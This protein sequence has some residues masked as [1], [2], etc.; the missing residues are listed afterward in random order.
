VIAAALLAHAGY[1]VG[2]ETVTVY[3]RTHEWIGLEEIV[4][5]TAIMYHHRYQ[6]DMYS[7]PSRTASTW[8]G[9]STEEYESLFY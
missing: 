8:L 7:S 2:L 9:Y 3:F 1:E 4:N 5:G 6:H